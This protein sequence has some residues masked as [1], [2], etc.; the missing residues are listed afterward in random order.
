LPYSHSADTNTATMTTHRNSNMSSLDTLLLAAVLLSLAALF[1]GVFYTNSIASDFPLRKLSAYKSGYEATYNA[2]S[3]VKTELVSFRVLQPDGSLE[4]KHI[5][6]DT[7]VK[8]DLSDQEATTVVPPR[9]N[10][11]P[12]DRQLEGEQVGDDD[13]TSVKDL[14]FYRKV[15]YVQAGTCKYGFLRVLTVSSHLFFRAVCS[16]T[17][18][19]DG[20][21]P[22]TPCR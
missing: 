15:N 4:I 22:S 6:V 12:K 13:S 16:D 3:S 2:E 17:D 19:T 20:F 5:D 14:A 1:V 8:N 7:V 18:P 10:L 11:R 9:R 21:S